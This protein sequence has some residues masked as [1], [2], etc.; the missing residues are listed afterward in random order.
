MLPSVT[1]DCPWCGERFRT[2]VDPDEG[3]ASYIE[4]CQVCCAPILVRVH[5]GEGG[6][7][8]WVEVERG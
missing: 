7:S 4:D 3:D 6:E 2:T 1:I 5:A 8:P